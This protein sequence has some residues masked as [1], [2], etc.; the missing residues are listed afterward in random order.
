M[1]WYVVQTF[2]QTDS[3]MAYYLPKLTYVPQPFRASERLSVAVNQRD[4]GPETRHRDTDT[5]T[6][7]RRSPRIPRWERPYPP[8]ASAFGDPPDGAGGGSSNN[9]IF[10]IKIRIYSNIYNPTMGLRG[11]F[12]PSPS[13]KPLLGNG[14]LTTTHPMMEDG[15][16]VSLPLNHHLADNEVPPPPRSGFRHW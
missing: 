9:K 7:D 8:A 1:V 5:Q 2:P 13:F 15:A 3:F 10:Q 12:V 4:G 16:A 6:H 11:G 14:D